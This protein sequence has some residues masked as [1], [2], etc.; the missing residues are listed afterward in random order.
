MSGKTVLCQKCGKP[1]GPAVRFCGNCGTPAPHSLAPHPVD[2]DGPATEMEPT[3]PTS[4]PAA[5]KASKPSKPPPPGQAIT[6]RQPAR[7]ARA[8][9]APPAA[10]LPEGSSL[11]APA[12]RRA[13]TDAMPSASAGVNRSEFQRLLEEVETGFE[14]IV[15]PEGAE[16]GPGLG[17]KNAPSERPRPSSAPTGEIP[18]DLTEARSLFDSIVVEYSRPIRDFMIEVRLGEPLRAWVDFCLPS[19]RAILRSA[20]GMGIDDFVAKMQ[21]FAS[22][23]ELAQGGSDRL[24]RGQVRQAII[25]SYSDLIAFM[26]KAFA[27]EQEANR[28]E[29]VIVHSLLQQVSS[30]NKVG[31][32]RI[33]AA[34]LTSL[35][36]FYVA[37]PS[38]IAELT[39]VSSELAQRVVDRFR[40]YRKKTE[41]LSPANNRSD[42][43]ESLATLAADLEKFS[44]EYDAIAA[45]ASGDTRRRELRRLRGD[46]M[47]ELGLL[48][49]RLGEVERLRDIEKLP[50]AARAKAVRV[51]LADSSKRDAP[52]REGPKK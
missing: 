50:F 34:G 17:Q 28:R 46:V 26:P 43:L 41:S 25:D 37:R 42:E 38:D 9:V 14:S 4:I 21:T 20:Q 23:C 18:N 49:A 2:G 6:A 33:Y 1:L 12:S 8:S 30:L 47:I 40:D 10:P 19:L 52:K 5:A 11:A 22:A 3:R 24:V 13:R 35:A 48:L 51:F 31:I 39:G 16:T 36:L 45:G 44:G 7:T 27:L 15:T 32:D 29:S